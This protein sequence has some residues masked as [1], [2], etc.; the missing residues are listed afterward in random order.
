MCCDPEVA[1]EP[2]VRGLAVVGAQHRGRVD[3]RQHP[4]GLD[5]GRLV[6]SAGARDCCPRSR[7]TRNDGPSSARPAVAPSSTT[8]S[9]ST[10]ASSASSHGLH[11]SM[12]AASGVWWT[13]R[14]PGASAPERKCFNFQ[15]IYAYFRFT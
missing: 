5:G 1:D 4:A 9:G 13:R 8:T 10:T 11:A 14:P 15:V 6:G 3:R 12:C 2:G 7:V